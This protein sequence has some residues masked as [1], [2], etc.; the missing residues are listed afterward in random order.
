VRRR[1]QRTPGGRH[2]TLRVAVLI[3]SALP[4]EPLLPAVL[5]VTELPEE[6]A[7]RVNDL[8]VRTVLVSPIGEPEPWWVRADS[9]VFIQPDPPTDV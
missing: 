7:E 2:Y 4:D 5:I 8:S 1:P 3:L 6:V 9:I